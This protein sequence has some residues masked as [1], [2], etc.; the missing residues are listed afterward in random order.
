MATTRTVPI[1]VGCIAPGVYRA[2]V[3][4]K[5][6]KSGFVGGT[7]GS[8]KAA[9]SAAEAMLRAEG[10]TGAMP[11]WEIRPLPGVEPQVKWAAFGKA[12][13]PPTAGAKSPAAKTPAKAG[14]KAAK[15]A[16]S[17]VPETPADRAA[18]RKAYAFGSHLSAI[19]KEAG[20]ESYLPKIAY[21]VGVCAALR[22]QGATP[23]AKFEAE[24]PGEMIVAQWAAAKEFV[25]RPAVKAA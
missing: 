11:R 15:A 6:A 17:Y 1:H 23:H 16:P 5:P 8:E 19:A 12:A 22:V 3:N 10:Y 7:G 14:E 25:T 24:V 21:K 9:I 4:Y 18:F 13:P 20:G 2:T